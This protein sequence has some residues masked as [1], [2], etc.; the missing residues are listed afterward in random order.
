[1]S[2]ID[3]GMELLTGVAAGEP[4]KDGSYKEGTV[5][6]L[7]KKRLREMNACLKGHREKEEG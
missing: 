1:V 4:Q 2:T 6:F 7:V 5:N 3:E